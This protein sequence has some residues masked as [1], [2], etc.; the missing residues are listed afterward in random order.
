MSIVTLDFETFYA[1]DYTLSK[2]TTQQYVDDPRFETIGVATKFDDYDANWFSGSMLDILVYLKGL[3]LE[4][5]I[6]VAHNAMF[7]CFILSSQFGIHPKRIMDT[8]SMARAVHG[9][10]VGGSLA[11]LAQHYGIGAKGTEVVQALGKHRMDFSHEE[12]RKYGEY[13]KN[14]VEL[15]HALLHQLL[16]HFNTGELSLIDITMKMFTDPKLVLNKAKLEEHLIEVVERKQTL[17][18]ECGITKDELMSNLKLADVLMS[19]GVDPPMKISKATGKESYAF[20][21]T[22]EEFKAL[23][24]HPD[25]RVQA[26]VAARMGVKSTLEETRTQRFIDIANSRSTLPI[27]L[28]YYGALTGRWSAGDRINMQNLPRKSKIKEAIEAP[29]GYV[30]IGADLSNIEL[31]VNMYIAGQQ[32]P[33]SILA[34][35]RDLYREFG[36]GVFGLPPEEIDSQQRFISKTATLGLGFGAGAKVLRKAIKQGSGVDVGE[37]ES[38]RLVN[39]F[40]TTYPKVEE[41]WGQGHRALNSILIGRQEEYGLGSLRL[42]IHGQRGLRLPS[43]LYLRYPGLT[44]KHGDDGRMEFIYNAGKG[45][46]KTRIYGPKFSQNVTQAVARCVLGEMI[47]E[48]HSRYPVV[49]TIHDAI[50]CLA[51]ENEADEAVK[52]VEKVMTTSPSWAWGLPLGVEVHC[53]KTLADV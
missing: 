4:K 41:S 17:L 34:E 42:P 5:H 1:P 53:G 10:E 23:L 46:E 7:D 29:E 16:P 25:E 40:R 32:E 47:P 51:P 39:A 27:P 12:L 50:Y 36:S 8:L 30:I 43:G 21:K 14:D 3:E 22:D 44:K 48:V 45:K 49:L 26:I 2:L 19:L 18:S 20:A 37:D 15:T 24:E 38:V 6:V 9:T 35:G 33:L 11:K 13:C 28:K 52:F 31:R